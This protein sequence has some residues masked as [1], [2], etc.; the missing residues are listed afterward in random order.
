MPMEMDTMNGNIAFLNVGRAEPLTHKG[1]TEPSGFVKRPVDAPVKLETDGFMGDEQGDRQNHGGP[2]KAVC[3]YSLDHYPYWTS[4]LGEKL[5]ASAAFGE[6][7]TVRGL[8]E[9]AVCIGDTFRV[10][11]CVLQVTQPRQPCWKIE[12]RYQM[13]GLLKQVIE[14]GY[15]GFYF[16]VLEPGNVSPG[17][18][19]SLV[20][21]DRTGM[22]VAEANRIMHHGKSDREAIRRLL[23]V[24]ALSRRWRTT[25][26]QR[27][28]ANH[29]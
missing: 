22:T 7:F 1:R 23:N 25:L 19:L 12:A 18:S 17:D 24:D 20:E 13:P 21:S 6:N 10:D 2:D 3:V 8:T 16:R 9:D 4:V 27:L 29:P 15:T 5:P 11:G 28:S 26:E 14:T